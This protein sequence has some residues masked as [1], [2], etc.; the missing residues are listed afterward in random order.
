MAALD[1][2]I[3]GARAPVPWRVWLLAA[4]P[5]TL[6]AA[7][8]PVWIGVGYAVWEGHFRPL[9]ALAALVGAVLIQV[10][11]NFANDYYDHQRGGDTSA[12]VG[13]VRVTQA[14][15]IQPDSVRR[16][17]FVM[18]GLAFAVGTYLVAVGGW[19]IVVI[20]VASLLS[21]WA[22]TGGPFP[23]AY[24]GLGDLFVLVF[25]GPVAVA[26]TYW[27]QAL[28]W[29]PGLLVAGI[30]VGALATAILV[31]NNLRDLD[32]DSAAGKRTLPVL[33]GRR[34][35]RMEYL[36][37]LLVTGAAS[38][39]GV[40]RFGWPATTLLGFLAL[41]SALRPLGIVWREREASR[42]MPA[43]PLTARATGL[44]GLLVGLGFVL[45]S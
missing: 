11:T 12:R 21:G 15:L 6:T 7:L 8:A 14:G 2:N 42:I 39:L 25:F 17:A 16:A 31:A 45:G 38:A 37:L 26:G 20:G 34:A 43:L 9:P 40:V 5:K 19:P 33:L 18:F 32:T 36:V 1:T 22:Y 4:R 13:P 28:Q 41:A 44:Y 29:R 24:N 23:L 35:G 3:E 10:G 30:A 27:V